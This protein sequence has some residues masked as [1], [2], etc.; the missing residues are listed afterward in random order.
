[1]QIQELLLELTDRPY[2]YQLDHANPLG[3]GREYHFKKIT[4]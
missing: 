3:H 1:M 4:K 2:G